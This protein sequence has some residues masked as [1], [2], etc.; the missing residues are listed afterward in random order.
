MLEAFEMDLGLTEKGGRSKG[1]P[2]LGLF[3]RLKQAILLSLTTSYSGPRRSN[4][5]ETRLRK[6]VLSR[7]VTLPRL[8]D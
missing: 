8:T 1:V 6:G 2:L 3:D 4:Q 5:F 7:E